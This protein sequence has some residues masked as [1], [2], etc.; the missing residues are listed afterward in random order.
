MRR[1]H[2]CDISDIA[3]EFGTDIKQ[4]KTNVK[5]NRKR[6]SDN[7]IFLLPTIDSGT[8]IKKLA[9]D[10][11]FILLAAVYF[12]CAIMG[13]YE[14]PFLGITFLIIVFLFSFLVKYFS[15][16]RVVNSYG[17]LLPLA[18]VIENGNKLRL[19]IFDVEVGDL[20]EFSQ[21]DIIPAD[22]RIVSA[23]NLVVAERFYDV[24]L[25]KI[26]YRREEKS[27]NMPITDDDAIDTYLNIVYAASMVVSGS[28]R[29]VVTNIGNDT[30]FSSMGAE[31]NLVSDIDTPEYLSNFS[32]TAKLFSLSFFCSVVPLTFVIFANGNNSIGKNHGFDFLYVFILLLSLSVT[33]MSEFIILPAEALVTKE[34]LISSRKRKSK[35]NIESRV[36]KL[37]SAEIIADTDT[38]LLLTPEVIIDNRNKVRRIFFSNNEYRYDALKSGNLLELFS[39]IYPVVKFSNPNVSKEINEIKSFIDQFPNVY[40]SFANPPERFLNNFPDSGLRSCVLKSNDKGFPIKYIVHSNNINLLDRCSKF[41]IEGG[42]IWKI[43]NDEIQRIKSKY[44]EY[45]KLGLKTIS[46]Y[47]SDDSVNDQLIFEGI[48]ALGSEYPFADGKL[49]SELTE[50][51]IQSILFLESE[52]E[53]SITFAENCGLLSTPQNMVLASEY[54]RNGLDITD[55]PLST[56]AY[57]GFD[58]ASVSKLTARLLANGRKVLPVIKDSADRR[59]ISPLSIYATHYTDSNDSVKISSSLSLTTADS[60]THKG[61]LFDALKTIKGCYTARLKL[62]VYKNYLAFSMFF[63]IMAVCSSLMFGKSGIHLTSIL[64][65]FMGFLCDSVA[66]IS[67]MQSKGVPVTPKSAATDA[68]ILHSTSFLAFFSIAGAISGIVLFALTEVLIKSGNLPI[69]VSSC[70]LTYTTVLSLLFSLVVFL[71]ILNRNSRVE[72]F[73]WCYIIILLLFVASLIIQSFCG[74]SVYFAVNSL[75]IY[76]VN[77]SLLPFVAI[78][79]FVSFTILWVISRVVFLLSD[80]KNM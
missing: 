38:L 62:G 64:V 68:K 7:T 13:Y 60:S 54:R 80:S 49:K 21:G 65:L 17:L 55:A 73:N 31:A 15:S 3:L 56:E 30:K 11:S 29:A 27:A 1:W 22:A 5:N 63:R 26:S 69:A 37:S 35:Y 70:F 6:R 32:R 20:I 74:D 46:F 53:H 79:A 43:E 14:E 19:S 10:A 75:N 45:L 4:G 77:L 24:E 76:R 47:S 34:L 66:L 57:I 41:R 16:M 71:Q 40:N 28:G 67:I 23:I 39:Y 58:G 52:N 48:I 44:N 72:A 36:T 59:L 9:S 33:C 78:F 42:G 50:S 8:V 25:Q 2:E 51:G 18:K 61:G 12:L